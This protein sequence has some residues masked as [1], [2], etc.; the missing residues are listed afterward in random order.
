MT[1]KKN[2]TKPAEPEAVEIEDAVLEPTLAE[3]EVQAEE[4]DDEPKRRAFTI[5]IN[6]EEIK[7]EDMWERENP[8]GA[9]AMISKPEHAGKYIVP[10]LEQLIGDDQLMYVLSVGAD[11]EELGEVVGAWSKARGVKN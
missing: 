1:A 9:L 3:V 10:L 11:A 6:G 5:E 4:E 7:L 2:T 8:P